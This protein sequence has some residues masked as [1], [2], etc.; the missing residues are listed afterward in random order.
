LTI[1]DS[2][3]ASVGDE[4]RTRDDLAAV[5]LDNEHLVERELGAGLPGRARQ[6]GDAARRHLHLM[7]ARLDDCVHYWHPCKGDSV[8]PASRRCKDYLRER[9]RGPSRPPNESQSTTQMAITAGIAQRICRPSTIKAM[10]A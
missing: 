8:Q 9:S 10:N 3:H 2:D 1:D 7:A 5:L 6:S 4:R